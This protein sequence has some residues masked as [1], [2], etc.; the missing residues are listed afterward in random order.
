MDLIFRSG[1]T[2]TG[3]GEHDGALRGL[4][5]TNTSCS[6]GPSSTLKVP[7]EWLIRSHLVI[8]DKIA[9]KLQ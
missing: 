9:G 6:P 5:I 7:G 3:N 2:G 8:S 4:N 1:S